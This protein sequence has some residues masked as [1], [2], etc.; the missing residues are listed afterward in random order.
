MQNVGGSYNNKNA[1]E[2]NFKRTFKKTILKLRNHF[3]L[4]EKYGFNK[5]QQSGYTLKIENLILSKVNLIKKK[6]KKLHFWVVKQIY[7][8]ISGVINPTNLA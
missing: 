8:A 4:L 1:T 2:E 7:L 6:K 5:Q 3:G